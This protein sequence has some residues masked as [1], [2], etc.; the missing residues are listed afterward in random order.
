MSRA[1]RAEVLAAAGIDGAERLAGRA[2]NTLPQAAR[3]AMRAAA[4]QQAMQG[5][6]A[7][8]R[9]RAQLATTAPV[10]AAAAPESAAPQQAD[11]G[12]D[13]A[14]LPA[15]E[16]GEGGNAAEEKQKKAPAKGGVVEKVRAAAAE[17]R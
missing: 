9:T 16:A 6:G 1:Q 14:P 13:A 11:T 17:C 5:Q 8:E 7:G 10:A 12:T 3:A 15:Y 4:Q 2:Y